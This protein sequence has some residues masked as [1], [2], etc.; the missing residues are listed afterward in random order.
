MEPSIIFYWK[1]K[2]WKLSGKTFYTEE[3]I[4]TW[5][6]HNRSRVDGMSVVV[7]LKEKETTLARINDPSPI[8]ESAYGR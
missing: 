7:P 5:Y 2:A 8:P 6:K 1:N 4:N 3:E